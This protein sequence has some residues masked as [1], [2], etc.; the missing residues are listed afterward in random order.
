MLEFTSPQF[1]G[2]GVISNPA[3]LA[4]K[5]GVLV[6]PQ[7]SL[8]DA[9]GDLWVV[10][11]G[12]ADGKGTGAAVYEFSRSQLR[13]LAT[14]PNPVP[15]FAIKALGGATNFNFPRFAAFD[16]AGNLWVSDAGNSAI[17]K[18]SAA[19]L[20]LST[21]VGLTPA[22]VLVNLPIEDPQFFDGPLGIA[23]DGGGNL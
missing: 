22:V 9:D 16:S 17:F 12:L 18:F 20:A 21:G 13:S 10:D 14:D 8:F 19:Q 2:G 11:G 7:D 23:F 3:Q 5:S 6:S 4:N 1:L 15:D